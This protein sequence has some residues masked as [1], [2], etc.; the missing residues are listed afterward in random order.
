MFLESISSAFPEEV[1]TQE[2]CWVAL[3]KEV[4]RV[5]L[6]KRSLGLLES[7]LLG[8]S[9]I[10]S[11]R[12]ALGEPERIFG[13]EAQGLNEAFEKHAPRLASEAVEKALSS[14]GILGSELDALFVATCTGYLCPGVSSHVSQRLGM[15]SDAYLQDLVGLG[16]GAAIPLL[17]S[18]DGF[19]RSAERELRVATVAV[20][21]CSSCFYLNDD[22][23][24]L[25]SLCLF[26]DGASASIWSNQSR[27]GQ[28][29]AQGFQTLHRPEDREKIRFVNDG[30]Y[31]KNQLAREVPDLAAEAV[32]ELFGRRVK[33]PDAVVSHTGGREV[34]NA[35]E[36]LFPVDALQSAR[37]V[38]K[39]YGN[40]SSPSVMLSLESLLADKVDLG[41][42]W[43]TS[44]GAGF[45]AHS[46][47]LSK[48]T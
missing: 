24:V 23:G 33:E 44:F 32:G 48:L 42:L 11:R 6:R 13:L 25:I 2:D 36:P 7:I 18:A 45:S 8:D 12:F 30:G 43:L 21:V 39:C 31:L 34:L 4:E 41:A 46:C 29:S 35:L 47:E 10:D 28:W 37:D 15:R 9:G 27:A 22:P 40:V 38:L 14:A 26:G 3:K 20:E 1:F 19:L 5:G 17:R 16:C